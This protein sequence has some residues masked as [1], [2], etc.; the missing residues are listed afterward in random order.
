MINNQHNIVAI[1]VSTTD[2][3]MVISSPYMAWHGIKADLH[4]TWYFSYRA[5]G[6]T[7][8]IVRPLVLTINCTCTKH[9]R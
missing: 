7:K 1:I 6:N 3:T 8:L 5:G 2:L 4:P 9:S